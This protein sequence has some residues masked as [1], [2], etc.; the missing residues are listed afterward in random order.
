MAR[1][2]LI[3]ADGDLARHWVMD[4]DTLL[5]WSV[6]GRHPR[7]YQVPARTRF[8]GPRLGRQSKGALTLLKTMSAPH[9]A[10]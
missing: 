9:T 8:V 6:N 2:L 3:E 1:L 10:N 4:P 7:P 5:S